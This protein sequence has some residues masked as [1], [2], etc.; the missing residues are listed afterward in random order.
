M[1]GWAH[2]A[3][4]RATYSPREP[5]GQVRE[6]VVGTGGNDVLYGFGPPEPNSEV[7]QSGTYGVLELTLRTGGY[8][9]RFLAAAGA[10]F[11]DTGSDVCH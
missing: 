10:A 3:T 2:R 11:T 8:D 9:W 1:R 5:R 6:F 7:R 4:L